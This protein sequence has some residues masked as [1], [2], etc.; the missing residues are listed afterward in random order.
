MVHA[1]HHRILLH[2]HVQVAV[3]EP[4]HSFVNVGHSAQGNLSI[5]IVDNML[6]KPI[7]RYEM[8]VNSSAMDEKNDTCF[9]SMGCCCVMADT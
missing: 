7:H 8:L 6:N 5:Q 9:D 2:T 3:T 4:C 1:I